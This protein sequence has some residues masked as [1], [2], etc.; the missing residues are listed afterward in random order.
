MREEPGEV[1]KDLEEVDEEESSDWPCG[2]LCNC[3]SRLR[4]HVNEKKQ[5]IGTNNCNW[6][7]RNR[8]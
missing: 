3:H 2:S 7:V 1:T 6:K 4:C 8:K 5:L